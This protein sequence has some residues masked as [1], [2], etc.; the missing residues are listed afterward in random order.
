MISAIYSARYFTVFDHAGQSTERKQ[1]AGIAQGCPL[2]PYLFIAVQTVMLHDV[3]RG[4][5]LKEE[6]SYVVTRDVLYADDTLLASTHVE[7]LQVILDAI[8]AAGREYGLELNWAKTLQIQISTA[9]RVIRPD[10]AEIRSVR[11]AVYLGGMIAC[12]ERASNELSRWLGEGRRV[13]ND[14]EAVWTHASLPR[15]RRIQI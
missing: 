13:F 1:V 3:Y 9:N 4:V 8:V 2:S 10:G 14:L 7:N 11:E 5:T 15:Q 12:D 6:P